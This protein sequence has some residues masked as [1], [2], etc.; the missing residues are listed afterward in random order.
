LWIDF[1]DQHHQHILFDDSIRLY[2][3]DDCIVN[4][5]LK[6]KNNSYERVNF[7]SYKNFECANILQ[8]NLIELLKSDS[9]RNQYVELLKKSEVNYQELYAK[10][11]KIH[12]HSSGDLVFIEENGQEKSLI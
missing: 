10:K 3:Y 9:E 2:S 5:R 11:E 1:S 7:S 4:V 6:N 12:L 8:P